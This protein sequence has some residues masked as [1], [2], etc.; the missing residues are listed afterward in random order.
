MWVLIDKVLVHESEI[1]Y[2]E[3]SITEPDMTYL[4]QRGNG[5]VWGTD[6]RFAAVVKALLEAKEEGMDILD[7]TQMYESDTM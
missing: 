3:E 1:G 2:F 4:V 5:M 7:L 6:N